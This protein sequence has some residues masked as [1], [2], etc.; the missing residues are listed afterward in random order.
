MD[1]WMV[2]KYTMDCPFCDKNIVTD[3]EKM[4]ECEETDESEGSSEVVAGED[5]YRRLSSCDHLAFLSISGEDCQDIKKQHVGTLIKIASGCNDKNDLGYDE[6]EV[7]E[8]LC[9]LLSE[10]FDGL[11]F[12]GKKF[13]EFD[14][15]ALNSGPDWVEYRAIFICD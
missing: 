3:Y 6:L 8:E 11:E 10:Y 1:Y 4:Y 5:C 2:E 12:K 13:V 9:S 7:E 15:I 14:S